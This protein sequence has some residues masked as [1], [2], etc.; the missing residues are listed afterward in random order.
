MKQARN[1]K[2][3]NAIVELNRLKNFEQIKN[4]TNEQ[5]VELSQFSLIRKTDVF[6]SG[7]D[8]FDK[9]TENLLVNCN[10]SERLIPVTIGA[11]GNCFYRSLSKALY[12]NENFY[13]ELRYRVIVEMIFQ[14]DRF[15]KETR[16]KEYETNFLD[17]LCPEPD[18]YKSTPET[19]YDTQV[20]NATYQSGLKAYSSVWHV[21][22]SSQ[23][24]LVTIKQLYPCMKRNANTDMIKFMNRSIQNLDKI[25]QGKLIKN[26]EQ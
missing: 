26:I 2:F 21:F 4:K 3:F 20:L 10:K 15:L 9:R 18:S 22:A 16:I 17:H 23:T 12:G 24:L 25:S 8:M 13:V 7:E 11:D 19:I 6:F 14:K 5:L 1:D